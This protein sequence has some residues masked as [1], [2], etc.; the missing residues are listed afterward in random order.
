MQTD[1]ESKRVEDPL[2]ESARES[3]RTP[4]ARLRANR[5][6]ASVV[7]I[8][9]VLY[10][11]IVAGR[12]ALHHWDPSFFIVAGAVFFDQS[13]AP[14]G[15][16][17]RSG[18][19]YDGQFYYSLAL[20]PFTHEREGYGIRIDSPAYRSQRIL[21]PVLAHLLALGEIRWI[22]WSM[23]IVNYLAICALAFNAARFAELFAAPAMIGLAIPF[24]PGVLLGLDRDLPD[25]LALSLMVFSLFLLH[26]RRTA[27][28]ACMLA[29]AVLARETMVILAGA[30]FIYSAWRALRKQSGWSKTI[31]PMIPLATY[32][33]WQLWTFYRWGEFGFVAGRAN[34]SGLPLSAVTWLVLRAAH[35]VRGLSLFQFLRQLFFLGELLFL[36][37]M[38][39]LAAIVSVRSAVD[40][41]VKLAWLI[42]LALAASLSRWVWVDDWAFMRGCGE[43]LVLGFLILMGA[44]VRRLSRIGLASTVAIWLALAVRTVLI[45]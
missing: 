12:L 11:V 2:R 28:A 44:R 23:I 34:L 40:P 8:T 37:E 10:G 13:Q 35:F 41:G 21:Y 22:P 1:A 19:G 16:M 36:A 39:L 26:S 38:V 4:L 32:A 24:L 5:G 6:I 7:V 9:A 14:Q 25:P 15:V 18:T 20:H 43:L 33:G 29:L 42:Y 17:V 3:S 27:L 45:E 30:L 31:A